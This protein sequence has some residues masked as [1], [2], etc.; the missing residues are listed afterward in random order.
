MWQ[1]VMVYSEIGGFAYQKLV[2]ILVIGG[3]NK[4]NFKKK[5]YK[6]KW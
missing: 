6:Y 3:L 2:C 1:W 4:V 5:I